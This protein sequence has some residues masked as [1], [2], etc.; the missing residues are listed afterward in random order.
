[1]KRIEIE[2]LSD[3]S[4]CPVVKAPG[5]KFPGVI[6]QGDSLK[7]LFDA[8]AEIRDLCSKNNEDLC[9]AADAL[10]DRLGG[11]VAA[12]EHAMQAHGLEL[13]YPKVNSAK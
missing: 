8:A 11:F 3:T 6:L 2:F 7:T 4:N 1:M 13:P 9:A 10:K 12:Y 5:R